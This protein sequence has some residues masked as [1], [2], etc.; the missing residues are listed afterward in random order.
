M[1]NSTLYT[2]GTALSRAQG[3]GV[4]VDVL[5]AGQRLSGH[6]N[7]LD[8][9]GLVLHRNDGVLSV[10]RME[11]ISAVQVRHA[12]AFEERPEVEQHQPE[13]GAHPMPAAP[14]DAWVSDSADQVVDPS[15]RPTVV[16][17]PRRGDAS[18]SVVRPPS[19][20]LER[21]TVGPIVAPHAVPSEGLHTMMR[22]RRPLSEADVT[23]AS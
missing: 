8:G 22:S 13:D 23:S 19:A 18:R 11:S 1:R 21:P 9:H 6:V 20:P 16:P 7:A 10:L 15:A 4:R 14:G 3:P 12:E 17:L 2:I 5:V